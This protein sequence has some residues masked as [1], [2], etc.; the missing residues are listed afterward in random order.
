MKP[1]TVELI[2]KLAGP[3]ATVIAAFTA[4]GVAIAFG[5]F[6]ARIFETTS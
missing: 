1:E 4:A 2:A 6:Q 5:I 3:A